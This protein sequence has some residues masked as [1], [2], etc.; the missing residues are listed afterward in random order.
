MAVPAERQTAGE[1]EITPVYRV[2]KWSRSVGQ[3][4]LLLLHA[5]PRGVRLRRGE[6][7]LFFP[8]R[9]VTLRIVLCLLAL[10][11]L[12]PLLFFRSKERHHG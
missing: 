7:T 3:A 9:D 1:W 11:L 12:L 5:A 10:G 2:R 8:I 6:E 4:R